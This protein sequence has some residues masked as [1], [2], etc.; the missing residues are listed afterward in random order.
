[1][2]ALTSEQLREM[3]EKSFDAE[4][5][6]Y[7]IP[8]FT[9]AC[10]GMTADDGYRI[11]NIR[12]EITESRG[13]KMT[14]GK[15]GL[16]SLEKMKQVGVDKPSYG[17]LFD[18]MEIP[19]DAPLRR[20]ELIQPRVEPEITFVMKKKLTGPDISADDVLEAA[21]YITASLEIIDS[22]FEN[23][24]FAVPDVI[25]DNMSSARFKLG[26]MKIPPL[27][28]DLASLGVTLTKNNGE[29][30]Y[31]TG[32]AVLGHP[33]RAI[34]QYVNLIHQYGGSLEAG[35]FVLSGA[36]MAAVPAFKGDYFKAEFQGLGSIDLRVE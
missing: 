21:D 13:Y 19:P 16:T 24:K 14:G 22:R 32:G 28:T 20:D 15:M 25:A 34:A 4:F 33:A 6:R 1:M 35:Q 18:Y 27:H 36:I 8:Q 12:R 9:A 23:F 11:Q 17:I 7:T 30:L 2:N 3:A 5:S 10:P 31:A 29:P 26:T